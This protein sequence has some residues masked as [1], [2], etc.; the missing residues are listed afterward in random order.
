[1]T[2]PLQ[3]KPTSTNRHSA[4]RPSPGRCSTYRRGDSVQTTG[5]S[6]L[7][8]GFEGLGLSTFP[9]CPERGTWLEALPEP[10]T[11]T[12][13]IA[14][15]LTHDVFYI[16]DFGFKPHRLA[17]Q[18]REYITTWLP[19]WLFIYWRQSSWDIFAEL[20]MVAACIKKTR[21]VRSEMR[22]L[23]SAQ[24]QNGMTPG[25]SNSAK[26]LLRDY[27]SEARVSFLQNYHTTLVSLM[28]MSLVMLA[29]RDPN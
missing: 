24:H 29:E 16:T 10:W 25:P 9:E 1:L 28:A 18:M 26:S 23:I 15:A 20:I 22:Q 19:T 2:T 27:H 5:T 12:N 3:I 14:Y 17:V 11:L 6:S 8:H 21:A 4:W 13:D 7:E